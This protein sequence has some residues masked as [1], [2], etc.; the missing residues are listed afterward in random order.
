MGA[1]VALQHEDGDYAVPIA[2]CYC[3]LHAEEII[4]ISAGEEYLSSVNSLK[5]LAVF[6]LLNT[7]G[8]LNGN[9][10]FS[11]G[12]NRQYGLINISVMLLGIL[13]MFVVSNAV[14]INATKL[15]IL[16]TLFY[17]VRV[18]ILLLVNLKYLL[19]DGYDFFKELIMVTVAILA[20]VAGVGSFNLGIMLKFVLI[21]VSMLLLNFMCDD[22]MQ[23]K[24][25]RL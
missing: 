1:R 25:L 11:S 7:L 23:L 12:R 6:S 22:Y 2:N 24:K 9:L 8:M 3:R 10:F 21:V 17:L 14:S 16:M 20:I 18:F 15:A 13:G 5:C 19:I 4:L